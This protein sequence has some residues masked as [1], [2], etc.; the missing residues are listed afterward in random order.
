MHLLVR[1]PSRFLSDLFIRSRPKTLILADNQ[2]RRCCCPCK[3]TYLVPKGHPLTVPDVWRNR[4]PGGHSPPL[5]HGKHHLEW[6][7]RFRN[8]LSHP[9]RHCGSWSRLELSHGYPVHRGLRPSHRLNLRRHSHGIHSDRARHR[10]YHRLRSHVLSNDV[11]LCSRSRSSI[12][13]LPEQGRET[14]LN[15]HLRSRGNHHPRLSPRPDKP[16]LF[17]CSKWCLISSDRRLLRNLFHRIVSSPL[18]PLH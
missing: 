12:L 17:D 16:R 5:Y 8:T 4:Q 18:F 2:R 7:P 3:W 11:V 13:E 1:L 6:R 9:L 15:S 10:R 14:Y